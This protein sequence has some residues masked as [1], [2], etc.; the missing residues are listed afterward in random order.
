MIKLEVGKCYKTRG[1]WKVGPLVHRDSLYSPYKYMT[2]HGERIYRENG[3][4]Y[5][6]GANDLISEWPTHP[7]QGTLKE[8]GAQHGDTVQDGNG[9]KADVVMHGGRLCVSYEGWHEPAPRDGHDGYRIITRTPQ[10]TPSPVRTVTTT[11]QEIVPGVYG[12]ITVNGMGASIMNQPI[13]TV[14]DYDEVIRTLT[15]IRDAMEGE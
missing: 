13:E 11:R 5:E 10:P 9:D 4:N 7:E 12:C 1:G 8:I 3:E 14:D 6:P 2:E 15:L